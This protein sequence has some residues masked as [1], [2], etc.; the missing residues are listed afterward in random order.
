[1]SITRQESL[2]VAGPTARAAAIR[3]SGVSKSFGRTRVL[4]DLDLEVEWGDVLAIVGPNGSGKSTLLRLL[5][6]LT[7]PDGGTISV[8]GLDLSRVGQEARRLMGVVTHEPLLYEDLT[9][10]ENL[11]F[12]A[13]MFRLDRTA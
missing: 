2:S 5:A 4:H 6:T 8:A 13:R 7:R 10:Y 1:M 9:A 3:L 12:H 11:A